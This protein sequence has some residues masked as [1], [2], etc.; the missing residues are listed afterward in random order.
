[1]TEPVMVTRTALFTRDYSYGVVYVLTAFVQGIVYILALHV[2]SWNSKNQNQR[3]TKGFIII[4]QRRWQFFLSIHNFSA[5]Q[6]ASFGNQR[7]LNFRVLAV[8]DINL[9]S[10]LAKIYNYL[11]IFWPFEKKMHWGKCLCKIFV[12]S[13]QIISRLNNQS[14]FQM[15]TP[16]PSRHIGVPKLYTKM[17]PPYWAL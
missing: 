16:F 6:L 3:A 1:M 5:H 17:A 8:R 7:I 10:C 4:R 9:R 12:Y 13:V 15:F 2:T 14:K 11:G